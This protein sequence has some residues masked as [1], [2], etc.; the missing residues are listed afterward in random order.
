MTRLSYG[1]VSALALALAA[2]GCA[3]NNAISK[4]E[5]RPE[6]SERLGALVDDGH[7]VTEVLEAVRDG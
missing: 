4:G 3:R 5:V 7:R 2:S 1:F 6:P